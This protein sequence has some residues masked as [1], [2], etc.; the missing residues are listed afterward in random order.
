MNMGEKCIFIKSL[1]KMNERIS[2]LS[3][4]ILMR[5]GLLFLSATQLVIV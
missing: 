4:H 3:E 2:A 1:V 5:T